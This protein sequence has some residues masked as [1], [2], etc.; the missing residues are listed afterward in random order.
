MAKIRLNAQYL[1]YV[2][3]LVQC[4]DRKFRETIPFNAMM[5]TGRAKLLTAK[6]LYSC[7]GS[8]SDHGPALK[9]GL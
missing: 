4:A 1:Q 9:R 5:K 3:Y 6:V 7:A 8:V 2:L